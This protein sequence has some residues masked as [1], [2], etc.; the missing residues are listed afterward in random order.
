MVKK[1]HLCTFIPQYPWGTGPRKDQIWIPKSADAQV[2]YS[3]LCICASASLGPTY[4]RLCSTVIF[5][6]KISI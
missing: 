3:A 2:P 5:I 6:E 1:P 4:C